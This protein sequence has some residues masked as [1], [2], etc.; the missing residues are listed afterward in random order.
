MSDVLKML[1]AQAKFTLIT[2]LE[3]TRH[4]LEQAMMDC[5][6][7]G[8]SIQIRESLMD[9]IFQCAS[10]DTWAEIEEGVQGK[11]GLVCRDCKNAEEEDE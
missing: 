6:V 7:V 8:D 3:G 4:T 5:A 1:T 9:S 2:Y 10:C 11:D